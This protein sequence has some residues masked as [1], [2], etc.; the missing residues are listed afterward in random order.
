LLIDGSTESSRWLDGVVAEG[1]RK[2]RER[3]VADA[4]IEIW[5]NACRIM[6]L[7][8]TLSERNRNCL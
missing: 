8:A 4:D 6:F 2:L 7:L 3:N 1:R 5:D